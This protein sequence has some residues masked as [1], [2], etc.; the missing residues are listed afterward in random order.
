MT[1]PLE[2]TANRNRVN[3]IALAL[4]L[5]LCTSSSSSKSVDCHRVDS[6]PLPTQHHRA[7]LAFV[8]APPL[9]PALP[10]PPPAPLPA[11]SAPGAPTALPSG[12]AAPAPS[13]ERCRIGAPLQWRPHLDAASKAHL[14]PAVALARLAQFNLAPIQLA[15]S[16][17][18]GQ[19]SAQATVGRF[20]SP[21][22][23]HAQSINNVGVLIEATFQVSSVLK[24]AHKMVELSRGQMVRLHYR[25]SASLSTTS[26]I[27]SLESG[28]NST[29]GSGRPDSVARLSSAS[30]RKHLMQRARMEELCAL[31]LSEHELVKKGSNLFKVGQD[32]VLFLDQL[33]TISK[34]PTRMHL[35]GHSQAPSRH[36]ATRFHAAQQQ[37]P[38]TSTSEV[39][40]SYEV[41][42]HPFA[43]HEPLSNQTSRSIH[44]ILCRNCGKFPRHSIGD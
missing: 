4:T 31:E 42:L 20:E 22:S 40:W 14:A 11:Q 7:P 27:I 2:Q 34:P 30:G 1:V 43:S 37:H 10:L 32:Y 18:S 3:M 6:P 38:A 12:A 8:S 29:S 13:A 17:S 16:T 25:V 41:S 9:L 33:T 5:L 24:R 35:L 39:F 21:L 19:P 15:A 36:Q 44:R 26:D 28:G 23:F